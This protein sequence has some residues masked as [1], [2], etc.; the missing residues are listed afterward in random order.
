[1]PSPM[2]GRVCNLSIQLILGLA[3]AVT[4]S[5]KFHRTRDHIILYHLRLGS[6]SVASYNSWDYG[7]GILSP[8]VLSSSYVSRPVYLGIRPPSG[9]HDQFYFS[10]MEIIFRH[11]QFFWYEAPSRMRGWLCN[12]LVLVLLGLASTV[13]L[14]SK[15]RRT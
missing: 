7:G 1:M 9:I 10:F 2:R 8:I 3:S 11:L 14:V 5:S 4:L 15:S 6:L 12:L 13:T